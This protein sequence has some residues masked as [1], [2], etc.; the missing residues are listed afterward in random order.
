[1]NKNSIIY[2][3]FV[4]LIALFTSCEKDGDKITMLS[5]PVAP[6]ISTLPELTLSRA[7][8]TN[9]LEFVGTAV[10]P[11]FNASANYFLEAAKSG[12]NFADPVVIMNSV[13]DT[14]M[15]IS[16]SDL[17]AILLKKFPADQVSSVDFRIRSIL[18]VDAG[19][20]AVG[21][22]SNPLVYISEAKTANVTVYGLPRLDL[23]SNSA[24]TGKI[25]SALGDGNYTGFVKLDN[26]KP[27][28]LKDPDSNVSYGLTGGALSVNGTAIT[29][30]NSGWHRLTVNTNSKTFSI[31][32]YM[33]AAV[34]EFTGW[35]GQPDKF[36]D[37]DAQSGY[38]YATLDLP[39]GPMKFR[40]NS[41]WATN[42]GPGSDMDLP[43]D[44]KITLPN[45]SG[46]IRIT[47][48]GKYRIT[49]TI[50]GNAGSA[51]FT[52]N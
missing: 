6:S 18:V 35:G 27:F 15:K 25:E 12:T 48:A 50:N 51:T 33:V 31:A 17:N 45:S 43:A 24:V 19:T 38:W 9:M 32:P 4:G 29:P 10:N 39:V 36:M 42:W 41:A 21:T 7:N 5:T 2:L 37:Y 13:Q 26:T 16:V 49:F 8:G 40:L 34:G 30:E 3:V 11:G 20:G 28:T 52:K 22:G 14:S 23:I 44:G 46:N 47:T 1:M